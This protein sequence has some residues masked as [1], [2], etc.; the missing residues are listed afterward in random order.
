[1]KQTQAPGGQNQGSGLQ[2]RGATPPP[3]PRAPRPVTLLP[4]ARCRWGWEGWGGAGAPEP[5]GFGGGG[6]GGGWWCWLASRCRK[7]TEARQL[8]AQGIASLGFAEGAAKM[9]INGAFQPFQRMLLS[10]RSSARQTEGL[11]SPLD[12]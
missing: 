11:L 4:T 8:T 2:A 12:G 7:L 1:M 3:E 6:G 9:N 10:T 5:R